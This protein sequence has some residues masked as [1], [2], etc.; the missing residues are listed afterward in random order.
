MYLE[1][2]YDR[3][4]HNAQ[5]NH[6]ALYR[7]PRRGGKLYGIACVAVQ[8]VDPSASLILRRRMS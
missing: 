1:I 6:E 2:P 7:E 3:T 5:G 8:R 4:K